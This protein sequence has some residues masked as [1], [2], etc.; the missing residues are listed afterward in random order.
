MLD[1]ALLR[2]GRFDRQV[3]VDRPDI[4]GRVQILKVHSRGKQIGKDVDFD[5]VARRTPGVDAS[6]LPNLDSYMCRSHRLVSHWPVLRKHGLY[7]DHNCRRRIAVPFMWCDGN[8]RS[9]PR[10]KQLGNAYQWCTLFGCALKW[11]C[12]VQASQ[13]QTCRT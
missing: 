13:E 3:T 2:P 5:K 7:L 12:M 1:S 11:I 4:S 10:H 8:K 9:Y 6:P